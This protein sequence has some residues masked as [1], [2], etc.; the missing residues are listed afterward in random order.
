MLLLWLDFCRYILVY[1]C[2]QIV[3]P[4]YIRLYMGCLNRSSNAWRLGFPWG[5]M[6]VGE[7][8]I[9]CVAL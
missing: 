7:G 5:I 2:G 9:L 6:E 4:F 3:V 1:F 8:Y